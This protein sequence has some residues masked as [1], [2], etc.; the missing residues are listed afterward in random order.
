MLLWWNICPLLHIFYRLKLKVVLNI[1]CL[2]SKKQKIICSCSC[3]WR[4][5]ALCFPKW[6]V[7]HWGGRVHSN[8]PM[9]PLSLPS[10]PSELKFIPSFIAFEPQCLPP[11]F[12]SW[13]LSCTAFRPCSVF[14]KMGWVAPPRWFPHYILPEQWFAVSVHSVRDRKTE[15]TKFVWSVWDRICVGTGTHSWEVIGIVSVTFLGSAQPFSQSR[16]QHSILSMVSMMPWH[17]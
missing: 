10:L 1:T 3:Q 11:S 2:V 9:S 4:P 17:F 15:S 16:L 14:P 12:P 7:I 13:L 5:S 6:F 8:S